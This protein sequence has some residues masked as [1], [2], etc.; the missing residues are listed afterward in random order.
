M[1]FGPGEGTS[2]NS[3]LWLALICA[4]HEVESVQAWPLLTSQLKVILKQKNNP[5]RLSRS[6][7]SCTVSSAETKG[8]NL[9]KTGGYLL[10]EPEEAQ[11]SQYQRAFPVALGHFN[12]LP[13]ALHKADWLTLRQRSSHCLCKSSIC[14]FRTV[15]SSARMR[16]LK[17]AFIVWSSFKLCVQLAR[18]V[19]TS[20][21]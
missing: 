10:K 16:W 12:Q 13:S 6:V 15:T 7:Q 11:R 18:D 21:I 9:L 4:S 5:K 20:C 19:S 17:S 14:S 1:V 2:P 8:S 3:I